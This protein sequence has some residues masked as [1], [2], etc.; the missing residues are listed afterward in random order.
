MTLDIQDF[1]EQADGVT[2]EDLPPTVQE[3]LNGALNGLTAGQGGDD[4]GPTGPDGALADLVVSASDGV[5]DGSEPFATIP[6]ALDAADPGSVVFV[7]PGTYGGDGAITVETENLTLVASRGSAETTVESRLVVEADGVVV[8]GFDVAP[9]EATSNTSGEALRVSSGASD[10]TVQNNVIRDFS[11]DGV[12]EF[13]GIGG[14]VAF[15][16]NA[17]DPVENVRI[18]NNEVRRIEGRATGGGASGVNVQGS[19]EGA[20]VR[21]NAISEIGRGETAYCFGV[22]VRGSSNED[23]GV[24]SDVTIEGNEIDG[25]RST[26]TERALFGVGIENEADAAAIAAN[27]NDVT[28]AELFAENKDPGD[29]LDLT[30]NWWGS[31]DPDPDRFL[32]PASDP[33]RIADRGPIRFVPYL[34]APADE[35]GTPTDGPPDGGDGTE[36]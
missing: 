17:D 35:G 15:G 1:V 30:E 11:E 22:V 14:I 7:E 6:A 34:D 21:D 36:T 8:D 29:T 26:D 27:G 24:P 10:V 13:E 12:G 25:I 3:R 19:V 33:D 5:D 2:T 9:P 18:V 28:N 20:L 31:V 23:A 32:N 16:G 4:E